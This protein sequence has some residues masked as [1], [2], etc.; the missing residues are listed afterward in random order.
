MTKFVSPHRITTHP[1]KS[2]IS[3]VGAAMA[4]LNKIVDYKT[5]HTPKYIKG[6]TRRSSFSALESITSPVISSMTTSFM[7]AGANQTSS[8]GS[9][10]LSQGQIMADL[11]SSI[12]RASRRY[13]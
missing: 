10:N 4:H 13:L 6:S 3:S 11:A 7:S 5:V 2:S 8:V 1:L 9:F 12:S